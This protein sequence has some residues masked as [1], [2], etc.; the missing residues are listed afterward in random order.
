MDNTLA[1]V[2]E[3]TSLDKPSLTAAIQSKVP[4]VS[5]K[6]VAALLCKLTQNLSWNG[7]I[8]GEAIRPSYGSP[9]WNTV[10][11]TLDSV[12]SNTE[13]KFYSP[14][15]LSNVM[16]CISA[17]SQEKKA[18]VAG[19]VFGYKWTNLQYQ[20]DILHQ[21][22]LLTPEKLDLNSLGLPNVIE[23][24]NFSDAPAHVQNIATSLVRQPLNYKHLV[25][26]ALDAICR[27]NES[28]AVTIARAFLDTHAKI[29][30]EIFF[31]GGITLPKPWHPLLERVLGN[32]FEL[33]FA[34]HGSRSLVFYALA[35]IDK[36]FFVD[37]LV[38][39]YDRDQA[40]LG[41]ILAVAI[42]A[43]IVE[44]LLK[45]KRYSFTLELAAQADRQNAY[46]LDSY[47]KSCKSDPEFVVQL[48][49]FVDVKSATD[50]THSQAGRPS[51]LNLRSVASIL[52]VLSSVDLTTESIDKL[53]TVQIQCLQA[54]P[55]LINFGQGHDAAVMAHGDINTFSPDVE[56]E[57]KLYYQKMYEQQI[58][59]RDI[60]TMLQRL[61]KSDD[62]HD[63]DVF[64]CMVHSL[65]DEY[66][67]FP[68]YPL[69]AL[70]TTAVLFGSLVYF[71]L[72]DGLP[73]SIALRF[74]LESLKQPPETN[75]FR[76]GLQA[77]FEFRQRLP[78]FPKYC[79]ILL[80]I[81]GLKSQQQFYQEIVAGASGAIGS[82]DDSGMSAMAELDMGANT[83]E[84]T[85]KS[86]SPSIALDSTPQQ[87][88]P[89]AV[90]DKVLFIVNNVALNNLEPKTKELSAVLKPEYYSWFATYIV[91]E[92]SK[93]EPNYHKLYIDM[94]ELLRSRLLEKHFV[95]VTYIEIIQLLNNSETAGSSE[96]R[97]HLK[98]LGQWLGSLLLARNKPILHRNIAFKRLLIEAYNMER[99]AVTLP[100]VCKT[101]ERA[102]VSTVFLPPNPWTLGI[103]E[104]LAELYQYADLKLNLKFEIEVLCKA[105]KLDI[106][107]ITP[108]NIVRNRLEDTQTNGLAVDLQRLKVEEPPV[109]S[110]DNMVP[111]S[112]AGISAPFKGALPHMRP[113][114]AGAGP[115]GPDGALSGLASQFVLVG[116]T[117]FANHPTLKR[118][119]LLAVDKA[120]HEILE[121]VVDRSCAIATLATRELVL[122]DFALEPDE[123][124]LRLASQN[125]V[126]VM[127][128]SISLVTCK[129]PLRDSLVANL[130]SIVAAN[131]YA[132]HALQEQIIVA[133]NE[134]L[135]ELCL[136]VEKAA[137]DRAASDI[138]D[139][140]RQA[141]FVRQQHMESNSGR[142]FIDQLSSSYSLQL[143][144]PFRLVPGGV[145]P[146]QMSIYENFGRY[147]TD[148]DEVSEAAVPIQTSSLAPGP[149]GTSIGSVSGDRQG[150]S[151]GG[152]IGQGSSSQQNQPPHAVFDQIVLQIQELVGKLESQIK[153]SKPP[154]PFA[155]L[156]ADHPVAQFIEH[157]LSVATHSAFRDDVVLKTSQ[158]IVSSLFTATDSVF[159]REALCSLLD[160]LCEHSITTA[161]EVVLWLIYSDDDRKYNVPVMQTL[162]RKQ[163][164]TASEIDFNLAKQIKQNF[165]PAVDFGVTFVREMLL[166]PEPFCLRTEFTGSLEALEEVDKKEAR[167]LLAD[168][169]KASI[170]SKNVSA[171]ALATIFAEWT[172]LVQHPSSSM[173]AQH[174]FIHD[175]VGQGIITNPDTLARFVRVAT[176]IAVDSHKKSIV[177]PSVLATDLFV[178]IDALAKF[179]MTVLA[180]SSKMPLKDRIT[181]ARNMFSVVLLVFAQEHG[182]E[183]D[184]Q[185]NGRPY[186][187]F[188]ST[189][190]HEISEIHEAEDEFVTELYV[191]L[192]NLFSGI[193][194][195]AFPGFSFAWMTLISHRLFLPKI[196]ELPNK[197]GWEP[198]A[199]LLCE[200]VKFE[201][202]YIDGKNFPELI[203]VMYKGTLR[204]F[205]IILHDYPMFL[206]EN[207][208][209]LCNNIPASFVQLRNL[210]LSAFPDNIQ[211]PDPLTQGLKVDKLPE[212][213]Q[214]PLLIVDPADDLGSLKKLI[215]SYLD[216]P[217]MKTLKTI[218]SRLLLDNPQAE[219]GIGFSVINSDA[220]LMHALVL[221]VGMRAVSDAKG[222]QVATVT[223]DDSVQFN[224]NSVYLKL[225]SQLASHLPV[226]SKYF[227]FSAMA[228]QLRYPNAH[229]HFYSCV[230]LSL[231]GSYGSDVLEEGYTVQHV[232]T[233]VLL[234]RMICNRPHPWGLMITF[235]EL[236]KNSSYKFW[237]LS[238]TKSTPEIERMFASLYGHISTSAS[239]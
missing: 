135:D 105:L 205:L 89:E 206:I 175:M 71:K 88:P 16:H 60:I 197:R 165:T 237:D 4:K 223:D 146:Q 38:D 35:R 183:Q 108:S 191:L 125:L 61:K 10:L 98:N 219:A 130:R 220:Q 161:K 216:E 99:L 137:I 129:D 156:P 51:L 159:G 178:A 172:R 170:D 92:R 202:T 176:N 27:D 193:Q 209:T 64:V 79:S 157:I 69:S 103:V 115:S 141:Y 173:R 109:S 41:H 239:E 136:V 168:L 234:E 57:M 91:G 230:I 56:R 192:A 142:P 195:L 158:M 127:A 83:G 17:I 107:K 66:R 123:N 163:L 46:S 138:E 148:Y 101:L 201:G 203:A 155:E 2:I 140:L 75:M 63:Q 182:Q 39:I 179:I 87:D 100:F 106:S 121:P 31:L 150:M 20:N 194:P 13:L 233:R 49:D 118:L 204:I 15:A 59:I 187:R 208:Y 198:F 227:L 42:E 167:S 76:F 33:F 124:K 110:L 134:H 37:A 228:N 236:L 50:Y 74:I 34:G 131:G 169:R 184:D 185:F 19:V 73:L 225:L 214:S 47:L 28:D 8:I 139:A 97:T 68:E 40:M 54:Y 24:R 102:S 32:F 144:D 93:Q 82:G 235:T 23:V 128:G 25:Y 189:L 120:I 44:D 149:S 22:S 95:C 217:S 11:E 162:I 133:V 77:L 145:T 90:R 238:F 196:L 166:C 84:E 70:A 5:D 96:K 80:E 116:T 212:I 18:Q 52:K 171:V 143:P 190:L 132:E 188:F 1:K 224:R 207:H 12:P 67:F 226:E 104:V 14:E 43:D 45:V 210:V 81:P 222:G 112:T 199:N 153:E 119:F 78:E 29:V 113:P 72:I 181:F 53:K 86:V 111:G 58:E 174:L 231:F 232:I 147:K 9:D 180:T 213:K 36:Q 211:L 229:T 6:M 221:Y 154:V 164:I 215:D 122:K 48:L 126:R 117:G 85:F 200:L 114:S 65:F 55:R 186:F 160:R 218:A 26:L 7:T 30:P 3:A 94:L 177:N 152:F 21:C 151:V 62:P